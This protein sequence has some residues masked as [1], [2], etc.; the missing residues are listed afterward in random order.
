MTVPI[1]LQSPSLVPYV[2]A[3]PVVI[4]HVDEGSNPTIQ[5]SRDVVIGEWKLIQCVGES[6]QNLYRT[7]REVRSYGWVDAEH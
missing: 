4:S 5:Q 2:I 1:K 6:K 3:S 7:G